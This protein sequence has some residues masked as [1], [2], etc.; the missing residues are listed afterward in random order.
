MPMS[1]YRQL[2][3]GAWAALLVALSW[4]GSATKQ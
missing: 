1:D 4:Y 2:R 3:A